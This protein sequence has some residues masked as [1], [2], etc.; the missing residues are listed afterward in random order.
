MYSLPSL[1]RHMRSMAAADKPLRRSDRPDHYCPP[2]KSYSPVSL[3]RIQSPH[4]FSVRFCCPPKSG[5]P[6][7]LPVPQNFSR[8]LPG[9]PCLFSGLLHIQSSRRP[10]APPPEREYPQSLPEI[11]PLTFFLWLLSQYC[12]TGILFR[13]FCLKKMSI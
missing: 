9:N 6:Y 1:S 12:S 13:T 2:A 10:D 4:G 11:S 7:R 8:P 5:Y 3:R